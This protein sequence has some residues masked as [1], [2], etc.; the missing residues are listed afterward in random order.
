MT[1]LLMKFQAQPVNYNRSM[2]I[3]V[4]AAPDINT[5]AT[6]V[7]E[8]FLPPEQWA[9]FRDMVRLTMNDMR[10]TDMAV[11]IGEDSAGAEL[12]KSLGLSLKP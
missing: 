10:K 4:G 3:L 6:P 9:M 11:E 5:K 2:R 12:M 1:K 7:G 8:F